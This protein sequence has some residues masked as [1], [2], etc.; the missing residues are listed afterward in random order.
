MMTSPAPAVRGFVLLALLALV[1]ACAPA[2]TGGGTGG[3]PDLIVAADIPEGRFNSAFEIVQSMRPRW[4][5]VRSSGS[6]GND[7]GGVVVYLDNIRQG[8]VEELRSLSPAIIVRMEWIDAPTATQRWG[9]GH[10]EGAIAISTRS[11]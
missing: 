11:R 4:L 9:T 10:T 2:A 7:D 5:R 8:G 1:A 6:L 3:D